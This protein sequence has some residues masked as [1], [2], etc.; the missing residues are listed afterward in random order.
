MSTTP[1]TL[2]QALKELKEFLSKYGAIAQRI[3]PHGECSDSSN[4]K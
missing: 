1:I 2:D 4:P 3:A